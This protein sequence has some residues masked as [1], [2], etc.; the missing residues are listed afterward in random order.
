MLEMQLKHGR[1]EVSCNCPRPL[2]CMFV[3]QSILLRREP[4]IHPFPRLRDTK[5][6]RATEG[7]PPNLI[8]RFTLLD[9]DRKTRA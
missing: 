1:R 6:E 7:R 8:S 5:P 2:Y 9:K 3:F 4:Q